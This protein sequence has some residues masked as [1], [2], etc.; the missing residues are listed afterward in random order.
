MIKKVL[1]ESIRFFKTEVVIETKFNYNGFG[2]SQTKQNS[3]FF[4]KY[5]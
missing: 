4:H 5:K 2:E 1:Y 3:S